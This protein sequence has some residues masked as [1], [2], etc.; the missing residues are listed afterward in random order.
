ML[1]DIVNP[2]V[3][4]SLSR[5]RFL[6]GLGLVAGGLV[7]S[8]LPGVAQSTIPIGGLYPLTGAAALFGPKFVQTAQLAVDQVNA[9]GGP[10]DRSLNLVVKD[11]GSA[12]QQATSAI[13]ELINLS[14]VPAVSGAATSFATVAVAPIAAANEVV[15]ISPS[16]ATT[17]LTTLDDHDFVFRT[18]PSNALQGVALAKLAL[19]EG[20]KTLSVIHRNDSFANTLAEAL[21]KAFQARGG[22]V[23]EDVSYPPNETS[24]R[25]AL[26]RVNRSNPDVIVPIPLA[27]DGLLLIKQAFQLGIEKLRLWPSSIKNQ[28]F[29]DDLVKTLGKDALEGIKGTFPSVPQS[30][31]AKRYAAQYQQRFGE[32]PTPFTANVYDSLFVIALAIQA[33]GKATGPA[34]RGALRTIANPPGQ[35]VG[36]DEFAKAKDLLGQGKAINYSGASGPVDF[37]EHGDVLA[38]VGIYEIHDGKIV[39]TGKIP[40]N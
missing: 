2:S 21:V 10:L 5:R 31:S 33:A 12:P 3:T 26:E 29:V 40:A 11:S 22:T 13:Q 34:I 32:A 25:S 19:Q 8:A 36:V 38:P 35:A 20:F 37:D 4:Y 18:F 1:N 28:E 15:L 7:L 9:A 39:E 17:E 27:E 24:F 23:L 30:L 6:K 14:G 16:A